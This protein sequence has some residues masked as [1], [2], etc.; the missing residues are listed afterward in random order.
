MSLHHVRYGYDYYYIYNIT[1]YHTEWYMSC[2][3]VRGRGRKIICTRIA[4]ARIGLVG[5]RP[6][7][8]CAVNE[9][10]IIIVIIRITCHVRI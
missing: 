5:A 2:T 1:Y 7:R 9:D 8:I 4:D 10:D 3:I 6:K